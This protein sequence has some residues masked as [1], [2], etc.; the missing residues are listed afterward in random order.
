MRKGD[1]VK[2][3][4]HNFVMTVGEVIDNDR[5]ITTYEDFEKSVH[6]ETHLVLDLRLV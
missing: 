4:K 2:C 1:R 5:V 6:R 3:K